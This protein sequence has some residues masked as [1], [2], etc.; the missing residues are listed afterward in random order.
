MTIFLQ[1]FKHWP[2]R[3]NNFVWV[4]IV[5]VL[6][7]PFLF[8]S[9][10]LGHH[11]Q[12]NYNMSNVQILKPSKTNLQGS[13]YAYRIYV[14]YTNVLCTS[15]FSVFTSRTR[16]WNDAKCGALL[17]CVCP[18]HLSAYKP[19]PKQTPHIEKVSTKSCLILP[20]VL[21]NDSKSR[22]HCPTVL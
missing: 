3:K 11:R 14:A 20:K 18:H 21:G 8:K 13:L 10:Y 5:N 15:W 17:P 9:D 12:R 2:P 19:E 4:T 16:R 1:M 6:L 22:F 7:P